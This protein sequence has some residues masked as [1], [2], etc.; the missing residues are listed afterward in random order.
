[1][2]L[3]L[4]LWY[5]VFWFYG[6]WVRRPRGFNRKSVPGLV[7]GYAFVA[8]QF[9]PF[10]VPCRQDAG[11]LRHR[12]SQYILGM[13]VLSIAGALAVAGLIRVGSQ[14]KAQKDLGRCASETDLH[15]SR[16]SAR[17][18]KEA[19]A[20]LRQLQ[21][22]LDARLGLRV[23][24]LLTENLPQPVL[25]GL[26]PNRIY[27]PVELAAQPEDRVLPMLEALAGMVRSRR[28]LAFMLLWWLSQANLLLLP[29]VG[30]IR[31]S[32][33]RELA[34][35]YGQ[36]GDQTY[37]AQ[38]SIMSGHA[39]F[40]MG[41]GF[42]FQYIKKS[43]K[44]DIDANKLPYWILSV[45]IP[46]AI[47]SW[48]ASRA[49]GV[50]STELLRFLMKKQI[51]GFSP[52]GFDPSVK[53][54][55]IPGEGGLLPD[56]LLV[57]TTDASA[58]S[59]CATI[60]VPLGLFE[61]EKLIPFGAKAIQISLEWNVLEKTPSATE[62]PAVKVAASEQGT[63]DVDGQ[64]RLHTFYTRN[65]FLGEEGS[66]GVLELPMRIDTDVRTIKDSRNVVYGPLLFIPAG[67]KI[68][69]RNY[70]V[71]RVESSAA[72]PIPEGEVERFI[73]WYLRNGFKPAL[74]DLKW[75]SAPTD[76][77]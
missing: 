50:D 12:D 10:A 48:V 41:I 77:I 26:N 30:P 43:Q 75:E 34:E 36:S 49:G 71:A 54:K 13:A 72:P 66:R 42:N 17:R 44:M 70:R 58:H 65:V 62:L 59:G 25:V 47:L 16:E 76:G 37:V 11:Y 46:L 56:G 3:H 74:I 39:Y 28:Y 20:G 27:V 69:F 7:M 33:E 60:R 51:I 23:P 1:M 18:F 35:R 40:Q 29:I 6:W 45:I 63:I 24:L 68:E 22:G 5:L 38:S 52:H 14:V 31:R 9:L 57:D 2:S 67:W 15:A 8:T 21:G 19:R 53:F 61:H 55:A 32:I 64:Q 4:V 73:A